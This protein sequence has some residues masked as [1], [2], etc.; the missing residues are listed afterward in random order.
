MQ[1]DDYVLDLHTNRWK[2][3]N[4]CLENFA[5]EGAYIKNENDNFLSHEY[6]EIYILLKQKLDL[7]HGRGG[8]L[9]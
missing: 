3:S 8:K 2:R 7:Y 4:H 5:L 1:M 6:R 9:Q